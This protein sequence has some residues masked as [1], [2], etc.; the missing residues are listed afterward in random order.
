MKMLIDCP[1]KKSEF[2]NLNFLR[3]KL[4]FWDLH[5]QSANRSNQN[6]KKVKQSVL[7]EYWPNVQLMG[8]PSALP[9]V[10][11]CTAHFRK[12]EILTRSRYSAAAKG[13]LESIISALCR[14][15]MV[16]TIN[17]ELHDSSLF[18]V[19]SYSNSSILKLNDQDDDD[20]SVW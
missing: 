14:M 15:I 12:V 13:Q 16:I 1:S 9:T 11:V 2:L 7:E 3:E 10:H 4:R 8:V 19:E 5:I 18:F 6:N 20:G 17:F